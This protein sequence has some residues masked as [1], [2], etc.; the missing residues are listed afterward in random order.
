MQLRHSEMQNVASAVWYLVP[1]P[2]VPSLGCGGFRSGTLFAEGVALA[3]GLSLRCI[4]TGTFQV[5]LLIAG[6]ALEILVPAVGSRMSFSLAS[7]AGV[8]VGT[9]CLL[10]LPLRLL[11]LPLLGKDTQSHFTSLLVTI[12]LNMMV[13]VSSHNSNEIN[14]METQH[15]VTCGAV[16]ESDVSASHSQF[17]V[18]CV[19]CV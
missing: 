4:P 11:P 16:M 18:W 10:P 6:H 19:W 7:V 14:I 3:V 13:F 12:R 2:V 5:S 17:C 9:W 1:C 15:E 8:P